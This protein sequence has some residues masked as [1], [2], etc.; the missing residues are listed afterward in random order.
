V[1]S[2]SAGAALSAADFAVTH[3]NLQNGGRELNQVTRIFSSST[4]G[5]ALNLAG[6]TAGVLGIGYVLH[7]IGITNWSAALPCSTSP[8]RPPP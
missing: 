7:R 3:A 2:Y 6:E 5:L 1:S 8:A 4:A